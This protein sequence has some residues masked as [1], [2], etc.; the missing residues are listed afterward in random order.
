MIEVT[1]DTEVIQ[2]VDIELSLETGASSDPTLQATWDGSTDPQKDTFV[3]ANDAEI[4][5]FSDSLANPLI[6]RI[7]NSTAKS[8]FYGF[9]ESEYDKFDSNALSD[10][11]RGTATY[12]DLDLTSSPLGAASIIMGGID[13]IR[14]TEFYRQLSN[15]NGVLLQIVQQTNSDIGP[16]NESGT[17][18]ILT[19]APAYP[20]NGDTWGLFLD[21]GLLYIWDEENTLWVRVDTVIEAAF[22]GSIG[23]VG[24]AIYWDAS[25][26]TYEFYNITANTGTMDTDDKI[27]YSYAN[28]G[29][30]TSFDNFYHST[31]L[32]GRG[33]KLHGFKYL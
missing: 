18:W 7:G 21:S 1:I 5:S 17:P 30:K 9:R 31:N 19:S 33:F 22:G 24:I 23:N 14:V 4:L 32:T 11:A 2:A 8:D 12:K 27:T 6:K 16:A 25:T 28:T 13:F 29:A 3:D 26:V 10:Y 20:A 15:Y